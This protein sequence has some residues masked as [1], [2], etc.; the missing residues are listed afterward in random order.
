MPDILLPSDL[1][2]PDGVWRPR[3]PQ[4]REAWEY[5][6]QGG[7]RLVAPWH[8]RYGKDEFALAWSAVAAHRR[9]GNYWHMLPIQNQARRAIWDALDPRTGRKRIDM[10]FPKGIRKNT[11]GNDMTIEFNSGS[12][13]QVLGSDNYDALVGAPPIGV[14]FSEYALAD[15]HAWAYIRPILAENGGWAM[16]ISTVR[17]R[18]HFHSLHQLAKGDSHWFTSLVPATET[19]VFDNETLARERRELI[20]EHGEAIGAA[21]FEQ[22]YLCSF[23]AAVIGS[24]YAKEMRDAENS[25]RICEDLPV[26]PD[27][28]VDTAWDIGVRDATSVWLLQRVGGWVHAVGYIEEVR[29]GLPGVAKMLK[30]DSA[31]RGYTFG[32]HFGPHDVAVTEWG[33][34]KTRIETAQRYGIRFEEDVPKLGRQEGIDATRLLIPVMKF[35]RKQ[36]D[37]GIAAL[38]NYRYKYDEK[39]KIMSKEP[40]HDWASHGSD[41]LRTYGVLPDSVTQND[42]WEANDESWSGELDYSAFDKGVI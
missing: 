2:Q 33:T 38:Q 12:M 22:E 40:L 29:I 21:M 36:C 24:V 26:Y 39:L 9:V 34:A 16:F 4:Q 35:S 11:R 28:P 30:E 20:E 27:I 1:T 17:G 23:D 37:A 18:N 8:R 10:A 31:K 15:P 41:A 14:V 19:Q 3:E 32:R 6:E 7:T 42:H 5:L 13:W 25:G